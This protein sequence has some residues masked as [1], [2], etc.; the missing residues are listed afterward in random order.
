MSAAF[1]FHLSFDTAVG[2]AALA[3]YAASLFLS[4]SSESSFILRN[5]IALAVVSS[6]FSAASAVFSVGFFAKGVIEA[7]AACKKTVEN[8][9]NNYRMLTA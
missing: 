4:E 1:N 6:L 8:E 3:Y 7:R 2:S 5:R 9:N